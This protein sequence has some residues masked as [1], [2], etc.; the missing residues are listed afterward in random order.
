MA[1][2]PEVRAELVG[3]VRR[4]VE[5]EVVPVASEPGFG[6]FSPPSEAAFGQFSPSSEAGFPQF[7]PASESG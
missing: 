3:T 2:D 4:F 1:T 7:S 6:Q 5:R